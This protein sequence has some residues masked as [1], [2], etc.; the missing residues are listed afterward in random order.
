MLSISP[1]AV[2]ELTPNKNWE[3]KI[4]RNK[5]SEIIHQ[6][7]SYY[8][9]GLEYI[10]QKIL[11]MR[12]VSEKIKPAT[13]VN[14]DTNLFLWSARLLTLKADKQNAISMAKYV[15]FRERYH[16]KL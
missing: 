6:I 4:L 14:L 13:Y 1:N 16:D 8:R 2:C 3:Q 11:K 15:T 7:S 5:S 12:K 10:N 9:T